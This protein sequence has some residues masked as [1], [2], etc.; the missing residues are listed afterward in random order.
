MLIY[1][2]NMEKMNIIGLSGHINGAIHVIKG[3]LR[4]G[5]QNVVVGRIT[6]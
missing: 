1:N 5:F 2:I 6:G 3:L 4:L